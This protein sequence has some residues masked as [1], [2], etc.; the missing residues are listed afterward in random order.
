MTTSRPRF[1][2]ILTGYALHITVDVGVEN[3]LRQG[4]PFDFREIYSDPVGAQ[5]HETVRQLLR[6]RV[7]ILSRLS[8]EVEF[9]DDISDIRTWRGLFAARSDRWGTATSIDDVPPPYS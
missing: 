9:I 4:H 6:S 3:A 2:S 8:A 1:A 7:L 5:P